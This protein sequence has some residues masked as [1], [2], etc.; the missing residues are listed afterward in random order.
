M[1]SSSSR[2][3][4]SP[5]NTFPASRSIR[6]STFSIHYRFNLFSA[7]G[8]IGQ[9]LSH[10]FFFQVWIGLQNLCS[11]ISRRYES[12]YCADGHAQA[13][14]ARFAPHH[15]LIKSN[16]SQMPDFSFIRLESIYVS[17][18]LSSVHVPRRRL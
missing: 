4:K 16:S 6:P 18:C 14:D 5:L 8:G 15:L 7:P 3:H 17:L 10:V 9:R 2:N 12:N 11:G 13:A 1:H